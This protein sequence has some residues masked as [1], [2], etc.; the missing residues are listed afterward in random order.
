[1][2]SGNTAYQQW[3]AK[4]GEENA[5]HL[6]EVMNRWTENYTHGVLINFG[7]AKPLHLHEQVQKI[8]QERGWQFQEVEGDLRL[9]QRWVDGEWDSGS[10]LIV[11]PG[12]Q[13]VPS[14]SDSVITT[15]PAPDAG[16]QGS[17]PGTAGTEITG[18]T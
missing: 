15:A 9:L 18:G 1:M 11:P 2:A 5:Q 17:Q 7:F 4:F 3:V 8:C 14:Y 10:F 12:H 6:L 16:S 13:V